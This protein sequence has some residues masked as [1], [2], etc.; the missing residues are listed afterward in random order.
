M[1]NADY[2][3][4][5]TTDRREVPFFDFKAVFAEDPEGFTDV[6][7][8]T[9]AGGSMILRADVRTFEERFAAFTGSL[10]AVGM[11][12]CTNAMQ[13]GVRALGIGS[14]DEVIFCSHTFVATAQGIYFAGATP[15]PVEMG[16]DRMIDP[17]AIEPAITPRTKAIMVTQLNGRVCD[18]DRVGAVAKKHGLAVLEDA[19]QSLGAS[20]RGRRAGAFGAF[21]AFSFYPSKLLGTFGDGGALTTDDERL[22]DCVFRMRNHGADRQLRIEPDS[23]VW[24]TNSRL[25]NLH[26]ALLNYKLPGF[27]ATLARRRQIA[28]TYHSAFEGLPDF[29]RPPG[30]DEANEHFDVFQNYEIDVGDRDPLRRHL[31]EE[32][33]GT[34][35]QWGG[36][37]VH[38]LRGLGFKQRLPRT[39]RF[40]ERCLLL[41]MNQYLSDAD[42]LH[43]CSTVRGH[44]GLPPWRE[45]LEGRDADLIGPA[46]P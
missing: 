4:T 2:A 30:P 21:G 8:T 42:V 35:L 16:D 46:R 31:Q 1:P 36:V 43:V 9:L 11:A 18:M 12:D 28:R 34:I 27:P 39:E 32:G 37:A 45:I 15:V 17:E 44:Y 5:R 25:D 14:G 6:F 40:F 22:A 38:Q 26:A 19:A 33:V 24:S 7:R 41:P 29:G 23:T 20:F 3:M 10:F 13:L